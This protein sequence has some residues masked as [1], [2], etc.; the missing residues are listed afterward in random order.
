MTITP[1]ATLTRAGDRASW[2]TLEH[3][4]LACFLVALCAGSFSI[5]VNQ[6][7]LGL[8]VVLGVTR[9]ARRREGLVSTGMERVTL[10][11]VV[12]A[13]AMI[14]LSANPGQSLAFSKRFFVFTA[15]WIG[16]DLAR[17][18]SRRRLL[19][20]ALLSGAVA[21]SFVGAAFMYR[22]WGGLFVTR[23][24][25]V[26]NAMT[27]GA[28]LMLVALLTIGVL[29]NRGTSGK[30]RLV[31]GAA[32]L[33]VLFALLMTM[34]RSALLG[35]TVGVAAM[36]LV[37]RPRWFVIFAGLG[38]VLVLAVLLFGEQVLSPRL[39]GRINPEYI[40]AGGNTTAR[41]EM[42]RVGWQMV[43][44]EPWTGVGD[45]DLQAVAPA[46]YG[47][48]QPVP[49]GHLHSNFVHLAVIWGIPGFLL[50]MLFLFRQP[51]LLWQRWRRRVTTGPEATPWRN[52]W[53]LGA[54]GMWA[55][56]FV[57]GATEWYFGDAE[58]MFLSLAILG[59]ALGR[60]RPESTET[61]SG[62]TH[63]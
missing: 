39:W 26:S 13:I 49:F 1:L 38:V 54:L 63:V 37:G 12:W 27:N 11:L 45:C 22:Q 18:E 14:P 51:R 21:I 4:Q 52:G 15:L 59:I 55:G 9:W 28:L 5:A 61:Q 17:D 34:T 40:A 48:R 2:Q 31:V 19:L 62:V 23:L 57:A 56:F 43:Q 24:E 53:Q 42:W 44:A 60:R 46:Y 20:A 32:L 30:A 58:P 3:A 33:P 7:A 29:L 36:L 8:T 16:A 6:I 41:L 10:L 50:A 35:L 25:Q 47:D